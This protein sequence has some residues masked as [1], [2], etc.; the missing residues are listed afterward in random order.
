M[1]EASRRNMYDPKNGLKYKDVIK[2]SAKELYDKL[3]S[4]EKEYGYPRDL[5]YNNS[6]FMRACQWMNEHCCIIID[7]SCMLKCYDTIIFEGGQG[8]LLDQIHYSHKN[9]HLTPSSPGVRNCTEAI[10]SIGVMPEL[11]YV[12]RSYATRHGA[13]DMEIEID[14]EW[15]NPDIKDETNVENPWQGKLRYGFLNVDTLYERIENDLVDLGS[16]KACTNLVYT[17][18]NYTNRHIPTTGGSY[19][20]LT[21]D[22]PK[23]INHIYASDQKDQMEL[24]I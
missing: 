7:E 6:N 9:C 10:K 14:K 21:C 22:K 1:F 3:I 8:L 13:G 4:I 15:I 11:Y 12:S 2:L 18:L 20:H 23:F 24:F 5:V 16:T 17:H 19:R